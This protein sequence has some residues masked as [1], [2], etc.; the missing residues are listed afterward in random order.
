MTK[1]AKIFVVDD[2]AGFV[3]L[4]SSILAAANYDVISET[5]SDA[6]MSRI[7]DEKPDCV[8]IDIMMPGKD[9]L[10][11]CHEIKTNKNIPALKIVIVSAKTYEFDRK[12]AFELGADGFINKPIDAKSFILALSEILEDNI[13]LAF[14]G[15]RGTLP[16]A[17]ERS[18]R[19]GGNTSCV[20]MEFVRG[21]FFIFDAGSGIKELSNHLLASSRANIEAKIFISHP[22]WD[23][24]NALPFF[25]PLYI[26]GNEFEILGAANA[27]RSMRELISAQMD[28]VYFP[29]TLK[30]FASRVYF[31]DLREETIEFGDI[32]VKTML[33]SHPGYCLGYRIEYH[34]RSICYITDNEL[35]LESDPSHNP[36]YVEKLADFVRG[37]ETLITDC[38]YMNDEYETKVG[39]G[40]SCVSQVVDL[41]D[42]AEV[43]NLYLFH[44]DPDQ[45]D[46]AIDKKFKLAQAELKKRKS[47]TNCF[48]P[49]E[50]DVLRL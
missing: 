34:G 27:D 45:D 30:E 16:V 50:G 48:A 12:R 29:I 40:H 38:T 18:L 31:R 42:R 36:S 46:K 6:A 41:A 10:E 4:A 3:K 49:K 9:G 14:W 37:T 35:F 1:N 23:H 11:L 33:L 44:H 32:V 7:E 26:Q 5:S 24:I 2:D 13:T 15:V 8:L 22:H 47:S 28:G 20:S 25:V 19:Y 21:D 43:K 39:W 17:G